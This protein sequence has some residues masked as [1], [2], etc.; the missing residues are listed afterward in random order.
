MILEDVQGHLPL[1]NITAFRNTCPIH[2]TFVC[3]YYAICLSDQ[4]HLLH[5]CSQQL[6]T[7]GPLGAAMQKEESQV[8]TPWQQYFG[9]VES[10]EVPASPAHTNPRLCIPTDGAEW[11]DLPADLGKGSGRSCLTWRPQAGLPCL[12]NEFFW[13]IGIVSL[14]FTVWSRYIV[15]YF[16]FFNLL[17]TWFFFSSKKC[18]PKLYHLVRADWQSFNCL[19]N[20]SFPPLCWHCF[21]QSLVPPWRKY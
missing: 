13:K 12:E 17:N 15:F 1:P 10:C 18:L 7:V 5:G 11:E 3:F 8:L 6:Q 19:H 14:K 2:A 16:I 4:H 20:S 21:F 9:T